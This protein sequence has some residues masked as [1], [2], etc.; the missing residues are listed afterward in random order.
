MP[1]HGL[2][3]AADAAEY[4]A[5]AVASCSA[6]AFPICQSD[7]KAAWRHGDPAD[8]R[9]VN[10]EIGANVAIYP[11]SAGESRLDMVARGPLTLRPSQN[12][13]MASQYCDTRPKTT[14]AMN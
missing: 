14:A 2:R 3:C 6:A 7:H 4:A 10:P 9:G 12:R 8:V 11:P 13:R 1:P 5:R